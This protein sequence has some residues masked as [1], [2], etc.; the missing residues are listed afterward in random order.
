VIPTGQPYSE[1]LA[2]VRCPV[3]GSSRPLSGRSFRRI[4]QEGPTA[5]TWCRRGPGPVRDTQRL[6]WLSRFSDDELAALA[7][8]MFGHGNPEAVRSWRVR[9]ARLILP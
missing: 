6:W 3:C 1:A 9:L 7:A 2:L 4:R 8:A 5:C